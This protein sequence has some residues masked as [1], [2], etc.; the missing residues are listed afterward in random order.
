AGISK[1]ESAT[2]GSGSEE[3]LD[4]KQRPKMNTFFLSHGSPMLALE[5]IPAG[6]FLRGWSKIMPDKPKAILVISAHWDTSEPIVS[7]VKNNSTIYDFYGFPSQLY[8]MQYNAPGSP[9][10]ARRVKELLLGSGIQTVKESPR[11]GLD[12]GAWIPLSMMYPNADI[13]VCQLSI[14]SRKGA[15]HH[16]KLGL[17]LSQ[18]EI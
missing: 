1:R 16:Y 9:D 4:R 17:A 13:P 5:D 7:V 10:L 2:R 12:H 14:Q 18:I 8:Q 6:A 15:D 3:R 11:R